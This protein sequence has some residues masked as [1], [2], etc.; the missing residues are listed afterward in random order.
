MAEYKK[1]YQMELWKEAFELQKQIFEITKDFPNKEEYGLINQLNRSS[2]SILANLAE[3]HGRYHY[4]DKIRVLYVVRGEIEETQSHVIV[5][6]S[7]NYIIR[8][9]QIELVNKYEEVK[10]K[11]NKY[12][13][14]L[15]QQN[16]NDNKK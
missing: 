11:V 16:K 14:N 15:I 8:E 6:K 1:F 9:K 13:S 3:S 10:M 7:R 4:L 12:I 5:A 2:N